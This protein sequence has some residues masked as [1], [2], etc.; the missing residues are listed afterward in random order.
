MGPAAEHGSAST[1]T[2]SVG[3]VAGIAVGCLLA[4]LAVGLVA[5]CLLLKR[6]YKRPAVAEGPVS[7]AEVKPYEDS[8]AAS[9]IQLGQFLLEATPD[10][11]IAREIQ[12]LGELIRQHVESNYHAEP[13][14][15]DKGGLE[16]SLAR[17]G[18]SDETETGPT[19]QLLVALCLD[20]KTRYAGLQHVILRVIFANIGVDPLGG[21]SLLPPPVAAFLQAIPSPEAHQANELPGEW[22]LIPPESEEANRG[23]TA[24]LLAISKW[25]VLSAFLLHPT[26]SMRTALPIERRALLPQAHALAGHLDVFLNNFVAT[27]SGAW[28][29]QVSHLEAVIMECAGL[30]YVLLSHP[31]M[32]V[33]NYVVAIMGAIASLRG[34]VAQ[35]NWTTDEA[36]RA[37]VDGRLVGNQCHPGGTWSL[38]EAL[39]PPCIA[40][41]IVSRTCED[42]AHGDF[43][44]LRAC[45]NSNGSSYEQDVYGCLA[46]KKIHHHHSPREDAIWRAAW[47]QGF[48]EYKAANPVTKGVWDYVSTKVDFSRYP[49]DPKGI[50]EKPFFATE[51]YYRPSVK[52]NVGNRFSYRRLDRRDKE[53]YVDGGLEVH[54]FYKDGRLVS[55]STTREGIT[56]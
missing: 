29:A 55:I 6:R 56:A 45:L 13:V 7:H 52:Q 20:P 4:G 12:S 50:A 16:R 37:R 25:R 19:R 14:A 28:Q 22:P 2:L 32:P 23:T 51:E 30:G 10:R 1:S 34:A 44:V 49:T 46:C 15:A 26:R 43:E 5:A 18:F 24:V 27:D 41:Q 42:L 9:D 47:D 40:E 48:E 35:G 11:D 21:H 17:L 3:A 31:T 8:G 36:L 33:A 38:G 39:I 54:Y 53:A